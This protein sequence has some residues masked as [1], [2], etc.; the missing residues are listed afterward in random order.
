M[1]PARNQIWVQ[2][3]DKAKTEIGYKTSEKVWDELKYQPGW[4]VNNEAFNVLSSVYGW[5]SDGKK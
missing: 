5:L 3:H 4:R 2:V 1:K